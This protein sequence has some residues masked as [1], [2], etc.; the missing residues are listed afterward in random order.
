MGSV[1]RHVTDLAPHVPT[2]PNKVAKKCCKECKH[3][4]KKA[5]CKTTIIV[6]A[7]LPPLPGIWN[8]QSTH[9][10]KYDTC[11]DRKSSA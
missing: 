11:L 5:M 9:I 3:F 7:Y 4:S 1:G 8:L 2:T 10:E 6:V